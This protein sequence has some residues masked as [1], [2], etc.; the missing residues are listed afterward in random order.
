MLHTCPPSMS[1]IFESTIF[2]QVFGSCE[3]NLNEVLSNNIPND[4]IAN[5]LKKL[6]IGN[7]IT[8]LEFAKSINKGFGTITKWEQGLTIPSQDT[9]NRIKNIYNLPEIYFD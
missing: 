2:G 5:K 4:T 1:S 8:Q 7:D 9:L 3:F 6:R